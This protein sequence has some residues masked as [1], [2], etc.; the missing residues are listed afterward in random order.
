MVIYSEKIL[1]VVWL[2]VL[3]LLSTLLLVI[4]VATGKSKM[5]GYLKEREQLEEEEP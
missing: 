1:I 2:K 5:I 4:S 3:G